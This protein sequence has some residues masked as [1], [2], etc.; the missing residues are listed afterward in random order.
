MTQT[1][2]TRIKRHLYRQS[3]AI[4]GSAALALLLAA[5]VWLGVQNVLDHERANLS[6]DFAASIAYIAEQEQFLR[7]VQAQA[8]REAFWRGSGDDAGHDRSASWTLR[9]DAA[10]SASYRAQ[11]ARLAE[12][13]SVR[14]ADYYTLFWA[15]SHFPSAS[16][17]VLTEP[18]VVRVTIPAL[19]Q[20]AQLGSG[21]VDEPLLA[22]I[23]A[24]AQPWVQALAPASGATATNG[25]ASPRWM[26]L[27]GQPRRMVA[28]L[29]AVLPQ[30]LSPP[31]WSADAAPP[32]LWLASVMS[33]ARL[34]GET[35]TTVLDKHQFW[36]VNTR[37]TSAGV[38][39]AT[40]A[41]Q[42]LLGTSALPDLSDG[43][44]LTTA[45][46]ALCLRDGAWR[47]CYRIAYGSFF[48]DRLWLPV[49][50][51][52]LVLLG[53]LGARGYLRW[54][55]RQVIDPAQRTQQQLAA[56]NE[57]KSTFLATMSHEIRTPLYG[58]LGT[59]EL[60][61]RTRLDSQQQQYVTRMQGAATLLQ[62]QISDVLDL[63][64][65]EAGKMSLNLAAFNV[66]ELVQ[67]T[68]NAYAD[69]ASRKGL[70][71][72]C[73]I[74][75]DAP[76]WVQGDAARL[77][78]I[79]ANLLSNAVKFTAQGRVTVSLDAVAGADADADVP[80]A[81]NEAA[82]DSPALAHL[83]LQVSDTGAG[84]AAAQ[85]ATLFTPFQSSHGM[86]QVQAPLG[87]SAHVQVGV[88]PGGIRGAGLGLSICQYL[89]QLMGSRITVQSEVG[90]GSCF[91][92]PLALPRV[93]SPP[94]VPHDSD[95]DAFVP[96]NLRLLVAEDNPINQAT[97]RNQLEQLGCHV[98]LVADGDAA[99]ACWQ[100]AG[101][102]DTF[103]ALLT[104]VNMPNRDGYALARE[105]RACGVTQPIIGVSANALPDEDERCRAAGMSVRLVKP[106][107]LA[108]LY[109][110]LRVYAQPLSTR[111]VIAEPYRAVFHATMCADLAKWRDSLAAH[112]LETLAQTLHR[113]RGGLVV[114][115][116]TTLA[117][118]LTDIET[119]LQHG[120]NE[121]VRAD[122][123]AAEISL[124]RL[125]DATGDVTTDAIVDTTAP[126]A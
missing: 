110:A 31:A 88:Q 102:T 89:A 94:Q 124:Q 80:P 105:L 8:R 50:A 72:T 62:Q 34:L 111:P 107:T 79:L 109:R 15:Y 59:L 68:A 82:A 101:L 1:P 49:V 3:L 104:D 87:T 85:L 45:G 10:F 30:S 119:A 5:A 24:A 6:A 113:I 60:L 115:G 84:I 17:L 21:A 29:P 103:D 67:S 64:T 12:Q 93:A 9:A 23:R 46:L 16:L 92:L 53:V 65:I 4:F 18:D 13:L 55:Q 77:R 116:Q 7:T 28:L 98:T 20:A 95:A 126:P 106:V 70:L 86:E 121:T 75:P 48:E 81:G 47:G 2:L 90:A 32:R 58:V 71:L 66:R 96:L 44:S 39:G 112:D 125:I 83:C 41:G 76:A 61:A 100:D 11:A 26:A 43:F 122:L 114:V 37:Y 57:A 120:L 117:K 78:Q 51:L 63:R 54:F 19:A 27:P 36:L 118:S 22:T 35:D 56:A 33:R 97:L 52:L 91:S 25:E 108:A 69:M 99:L 14:L 123:R 40:G 38:E 73:R 42:V 74:A